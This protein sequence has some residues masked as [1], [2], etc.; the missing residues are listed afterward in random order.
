MP[1]LEVLLPFDAVVSQ[2]VEQL[3]HRLRFAVLSAFCFVPLGF[4]F[5]DLFGA[6]CSAR[7]FMRAMVGKRN[8]IPI[9]QDPSPLDQS[10]EVRAVGFCWVRRVSG[11]QPV[12]NLNI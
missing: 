1:R 3:H 12:P 9:D 7:Y 2:N 5:S 8:V 10:C 11:A 6:F 4:A